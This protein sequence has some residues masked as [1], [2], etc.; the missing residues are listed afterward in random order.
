MLAPYTTVQTRLAGRT[1]IS[2]ILAGAASP[3]RSPA[4]QTDIRAI[5]R[6]SHGLDGEPDDFTVRDQADLAATA[7]ETTRVMTLLLSAIASVSL[8]V[9]GI[10]IMNIMLVS[11]TERTREIG[12]RR[13]SAP[14]PPTS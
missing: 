12:L 4:V 5:M 11:V 3:A 6:A 8:L 7:G 2:Q 13:R 1:F 9:G 14:A 10:G